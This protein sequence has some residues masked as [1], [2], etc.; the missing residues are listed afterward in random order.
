MALVEARVKAGA[1]HA[2]Y[3][4]RPGALAQSPHQLITVRSGSEPGVRVGVESRAA[5]IVPSAA[6]PHTLIG[7]G[8]PMA[9][10]G[11]GPDR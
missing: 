4:A 11:S 6:A 9:Q 3:D 8:Q 10:R 1:R 2:S 7:E 5:I